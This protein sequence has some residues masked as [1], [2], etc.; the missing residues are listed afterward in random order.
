MNSYSF[1]HNKTLLIT[2]AASGIGKMFAETIARHARNC[3][4]I[5][6]DRNRKPLAELQTSLSDKATV[7]TAVLDITNV[8]L[9]QLE[10]DR[11]LKE[12]KVPDIILNSAGIVV[13][14]LFHEHT[15][16]DIER[17]LLINTTGS[18]IVSHL[19]LHAMMERGSGTIVN[20]GSASAYIGNPRMSVYA[21][22]KW[23]IHGWSESLRL[24][25]RSLG[26]MI[27]VCTVIPSYIDTGMFEGVKSPLFVPLLTTEKIVTMMVSGIASQKIE[28]KAPFMVH[29]VPFL[30]AF[31]PSALFD[32]LAGSVLGVYHSMDTF[33]GK[34]G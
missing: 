28:I 25:L 17:T 6:W 32:W 16:A 5:L 30:K 3:T 33:Q 1:Y 20:M 22:S 12:G 24:E 23:A 2:G 19:F 11:L 13:G 8:D 18:M 9:L 31:L 27:H 34:R 4:L 10:A 26:S 14:K 15:M 7:V 21:A 29:L